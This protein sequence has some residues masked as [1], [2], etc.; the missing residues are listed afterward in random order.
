MQLSYGLTVSILAVLTVS[1]SGNDLF[2]P[3]GLFSKAVDYNELK[4]QLSLS[5]EVYLPGSGQFENAASRWS[6][7]STPAAS[8]VVVPSNEQ[9]VQKTV[10]FV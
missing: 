4:Q 9:D 3:R 5:A 1:V 2:A 8:I 7:A 6:N 10:S